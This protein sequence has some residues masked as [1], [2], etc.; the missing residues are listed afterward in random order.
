MYL[1]DLEELCGGAWVQV[2]LLD[3]RHLKA[4]LSFIQHPIATASVSTDT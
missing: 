2:E 4:R 1:V 3:R